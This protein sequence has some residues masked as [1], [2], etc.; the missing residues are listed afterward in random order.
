M[1]LGWRLAIAWAIAAIAAPAGHAQD[2]DSASASAR[3][4]LSDEDLAEVLTWVRREAHRFSSP[5]KTA[6][7]D[8]L[9]EALGDFSV[10]GIG[11]ATHGSHEDQLFKADLI[12]ALVR[13]G[14]IDAVAIEINRAPAS[15]LDRYVRTGIG[16]PASIVDD[17]A[18]ARVWRTHEFIDLMEWL[19][20]WNSGRARKV[21]IIGVDV[22]DPA[23]DAR[24]AI[25]AVVARDPSAAKALSA[26]LA[27]LLTAPRTR[28]ATWLFATD[29]AR[30]DR[31]LT[32]ARHLAATA[33]ASAAS[34][35]GVRCGTKL[36][37][38]LSAFEFHVPGADR[39]RLTPEYLN[40]RER[41]I[42]RDLLDA[43]RSRKVAFWAHDLHVT[44]RSMGLAAF[45]RETVGH[46][47][48]LSLG[49]RYRSVTFAW[50]FGSFRAI[51]M[52]ADF[53]ALAQSNPAAQVF[54]A[55]Q[56]QS[57]D[58]ASLFARTSEESF[59]I[60]LRA[61]PSAA[62][63]ERFRRASWRRGWIGAAF[64]P[65]RWPEQNDAQDL[66]RSTDFIVYFH[67]ISPSNVM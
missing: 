9:A 61:L 62:W 63:A 19:R 42:A 59:W 20:T 35:E 27:P 51:A 10:I 4:P 18:F 54:S 23:G 25:E 3:Q 6:Q 67:S 12:R 41:A 21:A 7:M 43:A 52:Q 57:R 13:A 64:D 30:Y 22:Q 24:C 50:S 11:E 56:D 34:A 48:T 15:A 14:K 5:P 16:T 47:A 45:A 53:A 39:T 33:Q 40:R 44:A 31:V 49:N 58:L 32:A 2:R 66:D 46:L 8:Q 28:F 29:P 1:S 36:V 17:P 38:G 65:A 60:D 55:R 37:E 26:P